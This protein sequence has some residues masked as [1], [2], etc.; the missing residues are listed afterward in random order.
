[1]ESSTIL[2]PFNSDSMI[3]TFFFFLSI[4]NK[5]HLCTAISLQHKIIVCFLA[6]KNMSIIIR[7]F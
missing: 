7:V 1:M 4:P 5:E 3:Y 2:D 6:Q